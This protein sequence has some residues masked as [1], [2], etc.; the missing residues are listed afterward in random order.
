MLSNL[1]LSPQKPIWKRILLTSGFLFI[2][3]LA[4]Y[5]IAST[6]DYYR[7]EGKDFIS[8]WLA[9]RLIIQG[10]DPYN[11]IDWVA[12]HETYGA[13]WVSDQ[14][15]LYP[16]P[17]AVLL[18]PLGLL[19]LEYASVL[20]V[21]LSILAMLYIVQAVL[22]L[23]K[24][25]WPITYLIPVVMGI[26]LFRSVAVS[27]WLGQ[28]DWL[29][30]LC[31]IGGML[32]WEK[33]KWLQGMMI[34][35]AS[36]IKPQLGVPL[37]AFISMWLVLRHKWKAIM[38]EGITLLA[39][40]GIGWLFN[41]AWLVQWLQIGRTKIEALLCCTPTIWGFSSLLCGFNLV[42]GF[43]LAIVASILLGILLMTR[44]IKLPDSGA[45]FVLGFS[46]PIALLVSPYLWTYSHLILILP[47]LIILGIMKHRKMSYMLVAPFILY[48]ALFSS[49]IVFIS[50]RV[51]VDVLSSLV[52][53]V[54]FALFWLFHSLWLKS[55]PVW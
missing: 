20:W 37:L 3:F 41:H 31:L 54:V 50:I 14:T 34:I 53:L 10:K 16:F 38:G 35:S 24:D 43:R 45:K 28:I 55:K 36:I 18:L 19:P 25:D 33:R 52:P 1:L 22:S 49:A 48:I 46:I 47:I 42:C 15:F 12:A 39:L 11:S 27:W 13:K 7:A 23:W 8:L 6:Q 29:I 2:I 32:H 9:P 51:G 17:L 30:L 40:F 21:A 26:F 4:A 5:F 44:L